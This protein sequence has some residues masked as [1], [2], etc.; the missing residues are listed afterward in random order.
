M[1]PGRSHGSTWFFVLNIAPDLRGHPGF[2]RSV[3]KQDTT[4]TESLG[5]KDP[6]KARELRDQRLAYW[7]RQFRM[8]R[9][10]PSDEDIQ[11]EAV[12]IF[13]ATLKVEA[14]RPAD[15]GWKPPVDYLRRLD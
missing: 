2:V 5:T 7:N 8:L 9:H 10:G 1:K 4:I 6:D 12:E 13:R 14:A 15:W 11:E 3:V